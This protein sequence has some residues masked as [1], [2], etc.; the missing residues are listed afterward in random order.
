MIT[1]RNAEFFDKASSTAGSKAKGID[2]PVNK[3]IFAGLTTQIPRHVVQQGTM[4]G[5]K[6]DP[7]KLSKNPML[8]PGENFPAT[9]ISKID[10]VPIP[11]TDKQQKN[12]QRNAKNIV[13][14]A[15]KTLK[16]GQEFSN[17]APMILDKLTSM[18]ESDWG[19]KVDPTVSVDP[20]LIK[21]PVKI[22]AQ[23]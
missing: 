19:F 2:D 4:G 12:I 22:T 23:S 17:I 21:N 13:L 1:P 20:K 11:I 14:A 6:W 18:S 9:R 10:G 16:P 3:A 15:Q 5:L 7:V 8:N